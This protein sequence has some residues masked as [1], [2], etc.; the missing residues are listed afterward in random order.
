MV[1]GQILFSPK[2]GWRY[3][4]LD[5]DK[6]A[7]LAKPLCVVLLVQVCGHSFSNLGSK[8]LLSPSIKKGKTI[9]GAEVTTRVEIIPFPCS[10]HIYLEFGFLTEY[11]RS[12]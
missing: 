3:A 10:I 6:E 5:N 9:S 8:S 1:I 7:N 11:V 4:Y 2:E 12:R